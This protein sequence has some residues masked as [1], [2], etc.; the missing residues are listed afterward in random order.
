VIASSCSALNSRSRSSSP[1][2][3]SR[4]NAEFLFDA[5]PA[6]NPSSLSWNTV[7]IGR[8]ALSLIPILCRLVAEVTKNWHV[9]VSGGAYSLQIRSSS[10]NQSI[11]SSL[12]SAHTTSI[13]FV[14]ALP[15]LI[16]LIRF[17]NCET[18]AVIPLPPANRITV[19]KAASSLC[20]PPYGPSK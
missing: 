6:T 8:G 17:N 5:I 9:T 11:A 7:L 1:W 15:S 18:M 3:S 16:R 4:M 10:L 20:I 19:S 2:A 13:F 14:T 12:F